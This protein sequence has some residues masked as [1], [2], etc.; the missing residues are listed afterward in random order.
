M[1]GRK[2]ATLREKEIREWDRYAPRYKGAYARWKT[3]MQDD[4][5]WVGDEE[6]ELEFN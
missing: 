2:D 4:G 1:E 6:L 5:V 3:A